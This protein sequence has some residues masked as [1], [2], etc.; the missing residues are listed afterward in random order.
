M[1]GLVLILSQAFTTGLAEAADEYRTVSVADPYLELRTG[2]GRGYPRFHVV[3]RGETVDILLRKTDWFKVRAPNGKEGW[4]DRDQL[5]LTLQPGG[6]E[7]KF[8]RADQ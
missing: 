8:A 7:I 6:Q 1:T 2:P 5:E 4:V 3:D